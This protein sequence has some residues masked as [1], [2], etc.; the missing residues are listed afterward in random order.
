MATNPGQAGGGGIL[1]NY[2][3][4]LQMAFFYHYGI[5]LSRSK[6]NDVWDTLIHSES[7]FI[8]YVEFDSMLIVNMLNGVMKWT[9]QLWKI[10]KDIKRYMAIGQFEVTH[11]FREANMVAH[12]M[13]NLDVT[14]KCRPIFTVAT[15]LPWQVRVAPKM[16]QRYL[17]TFRIRPK[18]L[19]LYWLWLIPL[20]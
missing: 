5:W 15:S 16:D 7:I 11:Y 9:W 18:R 14:S 1:R 3:G 10:I 17:P 20:T 8:V 4:D 19:L 13:A 2:R 12:S 6:S